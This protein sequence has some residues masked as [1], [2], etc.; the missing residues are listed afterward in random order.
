MQ[1][2]V[3]LHTLLRAP[4]GPAKLGGGGLEQGVVQD[5]VPL[6]ALLLAPQ[7]QPGVEPARPDAADR[8]AAGR[9][10]PLLH[11]LEDVLRV[12]HVRHLQPKEEQG[13]LLG[14]QTL[15][16]GTLK[17]CRSR[18]APQGHARYVWLGALQP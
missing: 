4:G 9:L 18:I 5:R 13:P 7:V 6:H 8:P 16:L 12:Q 3:S 10:A 17:P 2:R 15:T 14:L 11:A 1:D